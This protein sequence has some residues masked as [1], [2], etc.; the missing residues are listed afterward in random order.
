MTAN[1]HQLKGK[2]KDVNVLGKKYRWKDKAMASKKHQTNE[3]TKW[4]L[5]ETGNKPR[6]SSP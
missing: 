6:V 5:I 1:K 4:K 3:K 2:S